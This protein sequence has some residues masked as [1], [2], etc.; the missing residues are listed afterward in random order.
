M[1]MFGFGDSR[2][3]GR[4][5]T[6]LG[7][8]AALRGSFNSKHSIRVDGEVYGNITSEDG[9]IV[10]DKALVRGNLT[11]KSILVGGKV[12]GNVTAV[13]RLE[14]RST[15]QIEGDLKASVLTIEEGALFEGNCQMEESAAKVVDMPKAREN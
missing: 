9:I 13:H 12:K 14:V 2:S 1:G 3:M 4:M 10:G 7:Q 6:I 15:A 5:D 8:D 11:G